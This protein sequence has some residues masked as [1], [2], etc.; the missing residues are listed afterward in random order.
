MP[1]DNNI[2]LNFDIMN[3]HYSDY[4]DGKCPP[5]D[6]LDPKPIPFIVVEDTDFKF[7]FAIKSENDTDF[8]NSQI[9]NNTTI[10]D[11]IRSKIVES[12]SEYGLGAKTAVGYGYLNHT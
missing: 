10:G 5:A 12:F 1:V 6:Y 3:P 2:K 8:G 9:L 7:R 4:Y 11:F